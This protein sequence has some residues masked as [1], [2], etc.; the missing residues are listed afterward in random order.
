MQ[1]YY[2]YMMT[3]VSNRVL[4]TGVTN[5]LL[6]RVAEHALLKI[7]GFTKRYKT[8]KLVYFEI[9]TD[10]RDAI[11][12]EKQIKGWLRKKKN[13]LIETINPHWRDLLQDITCHPERSEGSVVVNAV[14]SSLRSE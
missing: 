5:D 8:T 14:D 10:I 7:D 1:H 9:S 13:A 3:N 11:A 12:R 4:Y 2:V 6:R